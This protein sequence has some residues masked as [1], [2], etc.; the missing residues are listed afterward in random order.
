MLRRSAHGLAYWVWRLGAALAQRLPQWALYPVAVTLG[1]AA[2]LVWGRR[3][4]IAKDNFARVLGRS[5]GDREVARVARRSFRNFAKYVVEIMRF[6]TLRTEDLARLVTIEGW[7]HLRTAIDRGR[8]LIFVSIHFGN[9]EVGGA[10]IA[11]EI[12]LNVIADDLDNQRLMDFLVGNR[13][14]KN[15]NI[16]T[17]VGAARKV[18]QALRR[19][20]MVGL[21]MDLGPRALAFDT[22]RTTFF[23]EPTSFPRVAADLA[24]VSGAPI[25]VAAVVREPNNTFRGI[26]L[27]PIFVERNGSSAQEIARVTDAIARGL[28]HFVSRWP[29]QWY[30]FRPMWPAEAVGAVTT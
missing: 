6:P 25:V 18:L 9:F 13:A 30:I 8:G 16:H 21:M 20:E 26:A 15:I 24:R 11:D 23:G 1:E 29:D 2:Y 12:P 19:N 28:E 17:P 4:R 3:R 7:E 22:V 10:R 14:H 27:P 5:A